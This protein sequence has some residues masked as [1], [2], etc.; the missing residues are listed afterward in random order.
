M[1]GTWIDFYEK[2]KLI[3]TVI[4]ANIPPVGATIYV[5]KR[6]VVQRMEVLGINYYLDK[7]DENVPLKVK[8][9]LR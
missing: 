2:G 6:H 8:V 1:S 9:T 4:D 7:T 3:K 5:K